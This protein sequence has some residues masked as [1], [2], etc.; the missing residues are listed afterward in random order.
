[1]RAIL[2]D[3]KSIAFLVSVTRIDHIVDTVQDST[4]IVQIPQLPT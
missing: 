2:N 3:G 1:M 4:L